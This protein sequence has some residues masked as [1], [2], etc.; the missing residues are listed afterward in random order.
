MARTD[1]MRQRYEM[2]GMDYGSEESLPLAA[3]NARNGAGYTSPAPIAPLREFLGAFLGVGPRR[4]RLQRAVGIGAAGAVLVVPLVPAIAPGR[5]D[6][7]AADRGWS[8]HALAG[9]H[10]LLGVPLSRVVWRKYEQ[11][12]KKHCRNRGDFHHVLTISVC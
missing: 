9:E 7:L 10:A 1:A 6:R 8:L 3:E 5:F 12:S 4:I 2:Q 11:G